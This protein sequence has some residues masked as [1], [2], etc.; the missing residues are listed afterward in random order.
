MSASL[1][2]DLSGLDKLAKKFGDPSVA[3]EINAIPARKSVAAMVAQAIADNF[4]KEGPGW[5]PLKPETIRR[6]VSA[7]VAGIK[8][9][10]GGKLKTLGEMTDEELTKYEAKARKGGENSKSQ[11]FRRILKKTG[12]LMKSATTPGVQHNIY[13]MEGPKL[14]WGTDLA[15]AGIHNNGF[16]A[17]NI[18]KRE[19]LIVREQWQTQI[20]AYIISEAMR[21]IMSKIVDGET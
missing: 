8:V 7:Q 11:P 10:V 14:V 13:R 21:I 9:K 2:L 4:D 12:A 1:T 16:P 3:R 17:K 20:E 5:Q 19:F 6:S 15:Y 18:P